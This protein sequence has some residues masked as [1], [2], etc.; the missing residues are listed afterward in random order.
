MV[1]QHFSV[2]NSWGKKIAGVGFKNLSK[3]L[4]EEEGSQTLVKVENDE[5]KW[6]GKFVQIWTLISLQLGTGE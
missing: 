5:V 2:S 3:S 1:L 4:K 6:M